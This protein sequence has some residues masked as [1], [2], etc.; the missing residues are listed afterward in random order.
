MTSPA[1]RGEVTE[2]TKVLAWRAGRPLRVSWVR[3]PPSPPYGSQE[4]NE[5][6]EGNGRNGDGNDAGD[7]GNDDGNDE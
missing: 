1:D 2:W 7:D 5:G 6:N 4:G 3:I